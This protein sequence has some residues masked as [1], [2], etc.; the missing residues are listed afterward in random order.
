[1]GL[2]SRNCRW[3]LDWWTLGSV[4]QLLECKNSEKNNS[5]TFGKQQPQKLWLSRQSEKQKNGFKWNWRTLEAV[6]KCLSGWYGIQVG[7][8]EQIDISYFNW[9]EITQ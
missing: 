7:F 5:E 2:Q 4:R 1:M 6:G 3:A 8:Y 9:Y